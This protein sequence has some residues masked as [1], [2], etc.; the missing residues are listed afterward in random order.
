MINV[1]QSANTEYLLKRLHEI[2][3]KLK[4][5]FISAHNADILIVE[6]EQ[7]IKELKQRK[8]SNKPLNNKNCLSDLSDRQQLNQLQAEKKQIESKIKEI[9]THRNGLTYGK[10]LYQ[11]I[12]QYIADTT[13]IKDSISRYS[14]YSKIRGD[15][16]K[17]LGVKTQTYTKSEY[18][19]ALYIIEST[20]N[21][22]IPEDFKD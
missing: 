6:K 20:L 17:Q 4:G 13:N 5:F 8:D 15:I 1:I 22:K 12:Q 9:T 18:N 21:Y 16:S 14:L 10:M 7:I 11:L 19:K 3:D 2:D